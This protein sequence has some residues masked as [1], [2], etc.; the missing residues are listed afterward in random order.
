[1]FKHLRSVGPYPPTRS[2]ALQCFPRPAHDHTAPVDQW[3]K[4]RHR[5]RGYQRHDG[6]RVRV[7]TV[8]RPTMFATAYLR[9]ELTPAPARDDHPANLEFRVLTQTPVIWTMLELAERARCSTRCTDR[10]QQSGLVDS[11]GNDKNDRTNTGMYE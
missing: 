5:R 1:M 2:A 11:H 9:S 7:R 8:L 10:N 3:R 4:E 6:K